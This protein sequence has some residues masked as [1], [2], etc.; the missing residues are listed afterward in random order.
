MSVKQ[1]VVDTSKK[2]ADY[3]ARKKDTLKPEVLAARV[4]TFRT[5]ATNE[6]V[7]GYN[8]ALKQIREIDG[9]QYT[10]EAFYNRATLITPPRLPDNVDSGNRAVVDAITRLQESSDR[11]L[12]SSEL[13]NAPDDQLLDRFAADATRS[14]NLGMAGLVMNEASR[15]S[16][17]TKM[18]VR[19]ALEE[20]PL[21]EF[22]ASKAMLENI[23]DM[24]KDLKSEFNSLRT[25]TPDVRARM[26]NAVKTYRGV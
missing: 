11:R 13:A 19:L 21:P 23:A 16:G 8:D 20:I 18:R 17:E 1:E 3:T 10:R 14:G 24:A 12:I 2:I 9:S 15:R 4:N 6:N 25:G 5:D 26:K 7:P 22:D